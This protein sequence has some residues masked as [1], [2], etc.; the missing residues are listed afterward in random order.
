M[1]GLGVVVAGVL[2]GPATA[3]AVAI[4]GAC[5]LVHLVVL[6]RNVTA[7]IARSEQAR[8]VHLAIAYVLRM[9]VSAAVLI[10]L[11]QVLEPIPLVIGFSLLLLAATVYVGRGGL[12]VPNPTPGT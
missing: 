6:G 4:G 9:A 5:G 1:I 12:L 2:S 10:G 11:I 8:P 3:L 7:F